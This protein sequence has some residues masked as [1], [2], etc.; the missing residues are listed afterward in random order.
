MSEEKDREKEKKTNNPGEMSDE[1]FERIA[2]EKRRKLNQLISSFEERER[3]KGLDEDTR[4]TIHRDL[5]P[6]ERKKTER[7]KQ[8]SF[9][10]GQLPLDAQMALPQEGLFSEDED[11]KLRKPQSETPRPAKKPEPPKPGKKRKKCGS[12]H[13]PPAPRR[14]NPFKIRP[15]RS[16]NPG[17][18]FSPNPGQY[19][20]SSRF[21]RNSPNRKPKRAT[22]RTSCS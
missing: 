8:H 12:I 9:E 5:F 10:D 6:G 15:S 13:P 17:K 11:I 1:I 20:R 18:R 3:T 14:R 19:R 21:S 16:R 2:A 4:Q 22:A 7:P